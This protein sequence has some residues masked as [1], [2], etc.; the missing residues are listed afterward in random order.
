MIQVLKEFNDLLNR[1]PLKPGNFAGSYIGVIESNGDSKVDSAVTGKLTPERLKEAI[2]EAIK[3]S[4][5]HEDVAIISAESFEYGYKLEIKVSYQQ[6]GN[7]PEEET[8][9]INHAVL[10]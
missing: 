5:D 6:D 1:K 3:E 10:Y 4:L 2:E 7:G 8:Y 9:Y